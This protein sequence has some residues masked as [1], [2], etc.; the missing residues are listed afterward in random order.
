MDYLPNTQK[1]VIRAFEDKRYTKE[2][3]AGAPYALPINPEQM[4]QNLRV[5][6]DTSQGQGTQGTSPN[7]AGTQAPDFRIEILLDNTGAIYGNTAEGQPITAQVQGFLGTVY[8]M[9]GNIHQ[10]RYLKLIWGANFTFDCLLTNLDIQYSIYDQYGAP[11]RAK[12]N[13]TFVHFI[14]HE[15]RTRMEGKR[16]PDLTHYRQA[17]PGDDLPLMAYSIYGNKLLYL[18]V[19]KANKMTSF[20]K[21]K[22]GESIVFP[23]I[24][25]PSANVK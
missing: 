6:Y 20:R 16:S 7:Y 10:P 14:E 3:N 22:T 8:K 17:G 2:V 25:K 5:R 12:I 23:P 4:Q 13:A 11:L 21:L 18:Q 15:L 1:M 24:E 9:E 19:A